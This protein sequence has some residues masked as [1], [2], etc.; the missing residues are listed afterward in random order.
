METG[1]SQRLERKG[2]VTNFRDVS[3]TACAF[4]NTD[5]GRYV[6]GIS[7]D[8]KVLGVH[9]GRLDELQRRLEG[10][11]QSVHPAPLHSIGIAEI[12]DKKIVCVD[13]S[14]MGLNS[15]C[16]VGG[17]V[18]KRHGSSNS[19]LEG[20]GL[21]EFLVQRKVLTFDRLAS[22]ATLEDLDLDAVAEFMQKT[23]PEMR[24]EGQKLQ[25]YLVN[26]GLAEA[27]GKLA[28]RNA[29]VLFFAKNPISFYQQCELKLV[30]F[31]GTEPI[32]I[33]DS[34]S[35]K[36]TVLQNFQAAEGFIR[37][38]TRTAF[39]IEKME[40]EE[41]PEYPLQVAREAIVNA[42]VH[43]DY[44]S[45]ASVQ[46]NIFDDRMEIINPGTLPA[47]LAMAELG[48]L[49]IP[50]NP[51]TYNL[52]RELRY[53]EG[54]GTGIARM[55]AGM[56]DAGLP[57]PAFSELGGF[58]KVVLRNKPESGLGKKLNERQRNA[59][60]HLVQY[61]RMSAKEYAGLNKI[62]HPTAVSDLNG[63]ARLGIVKRVGKARGVQYALEKEI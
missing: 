49:S 15:F 22:N 19:K 51:I 24:F 14:K 16:T 8:G 31:K 21:Q 27:N 36:G 34:L 23:R 59:M 46:I 13:V 25:K 37:K 53:I 41:I 29:A 61:R 26:L 56:L 45:D 54:M 40:R 55:R 4:A 30:R 20:K 48:G 35:A 12:G 52:M 11:V 2:E 63:M 42:L 44:F 9:E 47:G 18:Y 17:I 57:T 50:R 43:R 39:K 5:G 38:N 60:A 28:I 33:I 32:S 1:E 6:I 58:F 62:S 10:A 3:E 7:N